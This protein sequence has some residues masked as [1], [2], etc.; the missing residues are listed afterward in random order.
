MAD[1]DYVKLWRTLMRTGISTL[2]WFKSSLTFAK[3]QAKVRIK[4]I[5]HISLGC[6]EVTPKSSQLRLSEPGRVSPKKAVQSMT[7]ATRG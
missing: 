3:C 7:R 1:L 5:F 2:G 4:A 6:T